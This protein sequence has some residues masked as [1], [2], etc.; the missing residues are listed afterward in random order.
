MYTKRHHL[1]WVRANIV[2]HLR[3]ADRV[4][5]A[6]VPASVG[7][8]GVRG[9]EPWVV[10]LFERRQGLQSTLSDVERQIAQKRA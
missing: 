8:P 6:I 7:V 9:D 1:D 4:I 10:Q 5:S 2:E 3:H